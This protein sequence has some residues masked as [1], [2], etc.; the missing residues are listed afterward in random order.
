MITNLIIWLMRNTRFSI[1]SRTKCVNALLVK[2]NFPCKDIIEVNSEEKI[3]VNGRQL[4]LEGARQLRESARAMLENSARKFVREQVAFKAITLG[5]H[6]G[7]TP[8]K[9]YFS[10]TALWFG[11]MEDELYHLLAQE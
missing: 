3:M 6:N 9:L 10:R 7:D 2:L 4:D 5:I 8:E 1:E 11:Q